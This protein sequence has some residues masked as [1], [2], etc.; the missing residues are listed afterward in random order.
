MEYDDLINFFKQDSNYKMKMGEKWLPKDMDMT[1]A[2]SREEYIFKLSKELKDFDSFY[3]HL[4]TKLQVSEGTIK[5]VAQ[6]FKE[7]F[8]SLFRNNDPALINKF[9]QDYISNMNQD[10]VKQTKESCIGY[11]IYRN[12]EPILLNCKTVNEYLHVAHSYIV[13]DNN[14]LESLPVLDKK[15]SADSSI[16][17]YGEPS[18]VGTE[19]FEYFKE[20]PELSS[21]VDIV[22]IPK[23]NKTLVMARDL[24]H[25]LT[26]DIEENED[27]YHVSYFIPKITNIDKVNN[28]KGVRKVEKG[29]DELKS[30]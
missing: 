4:L 30:T 1:S 5:Q 21:I 9:Y 13:N 22:S 23:A 17:L 24:G 18:L 26:L 7:T 3:L 16:R 27:K 6:K 14:I 19:I 11:C 20:R 2:I 28:L 8:V 29:M 12:I 10:I 25:A 15:D